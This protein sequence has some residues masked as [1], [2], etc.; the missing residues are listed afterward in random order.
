MKLL[1]G[2]KIADKILK[3]IQKKIKSENLNPG[4]AVV[5]IG[6]NEASEVYVNL[7]KKASEK[8]GIKFFLYKLSE[9]AEENKI[10]E[11]IKVLNKDKKIS[12]IIVQ[13]PLPKR[14]NTQKI[15]DAINPEKDV[16]GFHPENKILQPVFPGAIL[17]MIKSSRT[18]LKNKKA[19]I[20]S[21]SKKFG[22]T[23][24]SVLGKNKIQSDYIL[25]KDIKKTV[26]DRYDIL[27]SAVG[28]PNLIKGE[29][30]KKG[31]I[32]ID[33]GITKKSKKVLGDVDL[34]SIEKYASFLSPVP[35]GVGP[36]T[37]ACLLKN[38]YLASKKYSC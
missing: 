3:N 1:E 12:G 20:V 36:V 7:K 10:I 22:E 27:I 19:I 8:I 29:M 34:E 13:L 31:A 23:M 4:L 30:I 25:N 38:V 28:K 17:E 18:N 35:G 24:K 5:L 33:G 11:K 32:V 21:N 2:K 37:I 16:D 9:D 15:I 6:K 26:S 14:L